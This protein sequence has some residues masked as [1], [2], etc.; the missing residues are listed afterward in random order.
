VFALLR[1]RSV[2]AVLAA[3]IVAAVV[4][5]ALFQPWKIVVDE[6]VQEAAPPGLEALTTPTTPAPAAEPVENEPAADPTTAAPTTVAPTTAPAPAVLATGTFVSHEHGTTG[7]LR[8]VG[9]PDGRRILRL[10][11]LDT[12]NGP[13]LHVWITDA[14][15]LPGRAGWFVFDD[16]VHVDLGRLKGNRGSQN[17]ELPAAVDLAGLE[18]VTIWCDR[19]NVS[20]G[21][22]TLHPTT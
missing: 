8:V 21:A 6:T 14:P 1:R 5:L 19:F 13:D 18:S 16:G 9:L 4:G 15:V 3:G 7:T 11:N 12:S 2:Q 10:E 17:Y 20:F 22:A